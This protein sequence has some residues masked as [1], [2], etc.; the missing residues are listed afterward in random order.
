MTSFNEIKDAW[1]SQTV[2]TDTPLAE[3]I[4][5]VRRRADELARSVFWRDVREV[6]AG[7]VTTL[8]FMA[9]AAFFDGPVRWGAGTAALCTALVSAF[10]LETRRRQRREDRQPRQSLREELGY[11]LR[12]VRRQYWLLRNITLWYLAPIAAGIGAFIL[13]VQMATP[14]PDHGFLMF[15]VPFTL[16]LLLA[17]RWLNH[18]AARKDILPR[19]RELEELIAEIGE[20]G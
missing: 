7:I 9:F 17:V 13:S 11:Q 10:I 1:N 3:Q 8:F 5:Q 16:A 2:A 18:R 19:Q 4:E 20:E 12:A 14:K 15:Y 6:G